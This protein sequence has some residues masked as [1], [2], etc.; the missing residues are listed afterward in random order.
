MW[1]ASASALVFAAAL[2][3]VA[4]VRGGV[5]SPDILGSTHMAGCYSLTQQPFLLEGANQLLNMG[6]RVIKVRSAA[7][8]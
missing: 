8:S 1:S 2:S 5:S 7:A 3:V 6:T 4:P